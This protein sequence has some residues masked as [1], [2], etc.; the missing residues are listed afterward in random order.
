MSDPCVFV[1]SLRFSAEQALSIINVAGHIFKRMTFEVCY[2]TGTASVGV[3]FAPV[4][5]TNL[6]AWFEQ[7]TAVSVSVK[8]DTSKGSTVL[9]GVRVAGDRSCKCGLQLSLE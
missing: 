7:D 8:H 1:V 5:G 3:A 9:A 2:D 4:E 6:K